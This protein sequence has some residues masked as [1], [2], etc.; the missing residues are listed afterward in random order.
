MNT[1]IRLKLIAEKEFTPRIALT[2]S[3][4]NVLT[5]RISEENALRRTPTQT[6]Y[7]L[8]LG[9]AGASYDEVKNKLGELCTTTD[10]VGVLTAGEDNLPIAAKG[11]DT[12]F[13]TPF[14]VSLGD[15]FQRLYHFSGEKPF[16]MTDLYDALFAAAEAIP[17]YRGMLGVSLIFEIEQFYGSL[18]KWATLAG[19]LPVGSRIIDRDRFAHWFR[20]GEEPDKNG[21]RAV[22]VGVGLDRERAVDFPQESLDRIFYLHPANVGSIHKQL[23]NHCFILLPGV[24][25]EE[26]D[27]YNSA[28]ARL[29]EGGEILD[30][31][32]ILDN[33]TLKSGFAGVNLVEEITD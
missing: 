21:C 23:H 4:Q 22:S 2:G 5:A 14:N 29:L 27:D 32:H 31:K 8:G 19:K 13:F 17:H 10:T 15:D 1:E 24:L 9:A 12:E 26:I 7:S 18:V 33:T 28:V 3:I 20:T 16:T 6:G 11:K 30:V 25:P